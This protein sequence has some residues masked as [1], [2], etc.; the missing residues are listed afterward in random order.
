LSIVRIELF[1]V[2]PVGHWSRFMAVHTINAADVWNISRDRVPE[3]ETLD[4]TVHPSY[5]VCLASL[6][7][8]VNACSTIYRSSPNNEWVLR[9][10]V[11][12]GRKFSIASTDANVFIDS[13]FPGEYTYTTVHDST[14]KSLLQRA[15]LFAERPKTRAEIKTVCSQ[16]WL[17]L[18]AKLFLPDMRS[19]NGMSLQQRVDA[20]A[21]I[22]PAS[23]DLYTLRVSY[24]ALFKKRDYLLLEFLLHNDMALALYGHSFESDTYH[25]LKLKLMG[26]VVAF[27][28]DLHGLTNVDTVLSRS[29]IAYITHVGGVLAPTNTN[30]AFVSNMYNIF[31]NDTAD[32]QLRQL[33]G[34]KLPVMIAALP[35]EMDKMQTTE[36][37]SHYFRSK[38]S[39]ADW[40][41]LC[42]LRVQGTLSTVTF[43]GQFL[44]ERPTFE[45]PPDYQQPCEEPAD[46]DDPAHAL[47]LRVKTEFDQQVAAS[48][49]VLS[50]V[51]HAGL[52]TPA[53]A[54]ISATQSSRTV[55]TANLQ[56]ASVLGVLH[57]PQSSGPPPIS[58]QASTTA[59]ITRPPGAT[60]IAAAGAALYTFNNPVRLPTAL[61]GE[62]TVRRDIW[63]S[64]SRTNPYSVHQQQHIEHWDDLTGLV[65]EGSGAN[66]I[67]R[68]QLQNTRD[69]PIQLRDN[70][71]FLYCP[72]TQF[73]PQAPF[74]TLFLVTHV[75]YRVVHIHNTKVYFDLM[76]I[77]FKP[78]IIDPP[79]PHIQC[80]YVGTY[81]LFDDSGL[82]SSTLPGHPNS[83]AG[84]NVQQGVS[85]SVPSPPSSAATAS[86]STSS[87]SAVASTSTTLAHQVASSSTPLRQVTDRS[88]DYDSDD[89]QLKKKTNIARMEWMGKTYEMIGK[90]NALH[91]LR[92]SQ[93]V[94]TLME[95]N[96]LEKIIDHVGNFVNNYTPEQFKHGILREQS[97]S[98][99]SRTFFDKNRR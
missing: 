57:Q 2:Y 89:S 81:L 11:R 60:S 99:V 29:D 49:T 45:Q 24:P 79:F 83:G 85:A 52:P 16:R 21:N 51:L 26:C 76:H 73:T 91:I 7:A 10:Q 58:S 62:I 86:A 65:F 77:L 70:L 18:L 48:N 53:N 1:L 32:I 96:H 39:K 13:Y 47:A 15:Q 87:T 37:W 17:T 97:K 71:V 6:I 46:Q 38:K 3:F 5:D 66:Y 25:K 74:D 4:S 94:R 61:F 92:M 35:R 50:G 82:S 44:D 27:L 54:A 42:K 40:E 78:A 31:S 43:P 33:L 41:S 59:V 80:Q 12:K 30:R 68:L 72:D 64:Y 93:S 56:Q 69:R 98:D 84:N 55:T 14:G 20:L 88:T 63:A 34:K 22:N 9:R 36:K 75:R 95:P 8:L 67:Q 19:V 90:E 28:Q 23:F